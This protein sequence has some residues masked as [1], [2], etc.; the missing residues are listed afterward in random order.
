MPNPRAPFHS[1]T[2]EVAANPSS[3]QIVWPPV[4]VGEVTFHLKR[5]PAFIALLA[6]GY[7]PVYPCH[8]SPRDMRQHPIGTGPF[9]FGEFKPNES[10]RVNQ[11]VLAV[12]VMGCGLCGSTRSR[13]AFNASVWG[14][15]D[16]GSKSTSR[17]SAVIRTARSLSVRSSRCIMSKGALRMLQGSPG[18]PARGVALSSVRCSIWPELAIPQCQPGSDWR[19]SV[20]RCLSPAS[21]A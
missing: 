21:P 4:I 5:Q 18:E 15:S 9:K 3:A 13:M 17:R 14:D 20:T 12:S 10:I 2:S 16:R 8:V 1:C 7:S 19:L 6:S 11:P